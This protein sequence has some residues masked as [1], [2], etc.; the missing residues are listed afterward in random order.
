LLAFCILSPSFRP[1]VS[2]T[3][4]RAWIE[5]GRDVFGKTTHYALQV[6][7]GWKLFVQSHK[8]DRVR[9]LGRMIVKAGKKSGPE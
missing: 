5:I 8:F 2:T 3:L 6:S 4:I 9:P 1:E 7:K